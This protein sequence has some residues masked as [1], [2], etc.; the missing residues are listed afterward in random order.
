MRP[1]PMPIASVLMQ[2]IHALPLISLVED[3]R[4]N[5]GEQGRCNHREPS[6]ANESEGAHA[7]STCHSNHNTGDRRERTKR[8]GGQVEHV[9]HTR[10]GTA[11]AVGHVTTDGSQSRHGCNTRTRQSGHETDGARKDT[12]HARVT[13]TGGLGS[14]DHV[15]DQARDF[16]TCSEEFSTDDQGNDGSKHTAHGLKELRAVLHR[17]HEA[18]RTKDFYQS[19][20]GP[21]N[22][23]SRHDVQLHTLDAERGEDQ[24]DDDRS[25]RQKR[26]VPFSDFPGFA[27]SDAPPLLRGFLSYGIMSVIFM[28]LMFMLFLSMF[29]KVKCGSPIIVKI[30]SV[31]TLDKLASLV[32]ICKSS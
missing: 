27:I 30:F 1:N 16:K 22:E 29:I 3:H 2:L 24:H 26:I 8:A 19:G 5:E 7:R 13:E 32:Y 4:Q 31:F 9:L 20:N 23:Q 11:E 18:T 28:F 21:A 25:N 6:T 10:N 14:F 17:S 15:G 12:H